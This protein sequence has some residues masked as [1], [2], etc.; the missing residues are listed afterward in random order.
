MSSFLKFFSSS[1]GTKILIGLTGLLFFGFL[2]LHLAGNLLVLMDDDAFNAYSHKLISN[3]L[4]Y[5]AELGLLAIFVLHVYKT[6][7]NYVRNLRARPTRYETKRWAGHTSRKTLASS[8]MIVTGLVVLL[9]L[10]I[11]LAHFK[12]GVYYE[13]AAHGYR[14]LA[15]LVRETFVQPV[16][17]IWYVVV[18]TLIGLHLRHGIGSAFQSLG[19]EHP[20]YNAWVRALGIVLAVLVAGGFAL[21]PIWIFVTGGRS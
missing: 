7:T 6:L 2:I 8:S 17:V 12:F 3:P 1:V 11:H 13:D 10:T 15:R 9:F 4:I 14:D 16:W 20:R 19:L 18:M 21:I 5:L